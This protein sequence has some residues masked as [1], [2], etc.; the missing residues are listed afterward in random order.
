MYQ[1]MQKRR[2]IHH[3]WQFNGAFIDGPLTSLLFSFT[4][5]PPPPFSPLWLTDRRVCTSTTWHMHTHKKPFPSHWLHGKC[6]ETGIG[7]E[8]G[9]IRSNP[10]SPGN[11]TSPLPSLL[12]TMKSSQTRIRTE[13]ML[14]Q[15]APA[16]RSLSMNL[17]LIKSGSAATLLMDTKSSCL[18]YKSV[19][20]WVMLHSLM[21]TLS[22]RNELLF[23][24]NEMHH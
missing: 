3:N 19:S 5:T 10:P 2:N 23:F 1:L 4:V 6:F 11:W 24:Y 18:L 7:S 22:W 16:N 17:P 20:Y 12:R 9:Y 13:D 14:L 21:I 15:T 8:G